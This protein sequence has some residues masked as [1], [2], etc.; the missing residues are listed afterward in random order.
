MLVELLMFVK[1]MSGDDMPTYR[2]TKH[3]YQSM[4]ECLTQ[5]NK[6]KH[7]PVLNQV[8]QFHQGR[9]QAKPHSN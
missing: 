5:L 8:T 2:Y 7:D 4:D 6:L 9:C 1:V 3:S